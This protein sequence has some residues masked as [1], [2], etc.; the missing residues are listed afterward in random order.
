MFRERR[1]CQNVSG[2]YAVGSMCKPCSKELIGCDQ[3][4]PPNRNGMLKCTRCSGGFNRITIGEASICVFSFHIYIPNAPDDYKVTEPICV[5]TCGTCLAAGPTGCLTCATGFYFILDSRIAGYAPVIVLQ[6]IIKVKL[7]LSS[8]RIV[9]VVA[10]DVLK[11]FVVLD[12]LLLDI[13]LEIR[14]DNTHG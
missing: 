10:Q 5:V 11:L 4:D 8:A 2:V 12:M 14:K 1:R 9:V 7:L 13:S 3:C 6:G